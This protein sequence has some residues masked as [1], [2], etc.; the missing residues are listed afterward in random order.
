MKDNKVRLLVRGALLAA[1]CFV[2]TRVVTIPAPTGYV[3]LGDCAVLLS[4]WMLGPVYG[5]LAAG[6]GTL[7]ADI[8]SGYGSYAP[9]TFVIKFTM[10]VVAALLMRFL[11][12]RG[13]LPAVVCAAV[14]AEVIMA[15]G[16][17]VYESLVLGV[18]AAAMASVP[19]NAVQGAIGGVAGTAL[20]LA[21]EHTPLRRL[22][23][24]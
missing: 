15:L 5:G 14:V 24:S 19:A 22:R 13:T 16:Y 17:F 18:G 23:E 20:I 1:L 21:L 6:I 7:L 9:G 11:A 10:A 3:N 4:A 12:H 2:L 8:L